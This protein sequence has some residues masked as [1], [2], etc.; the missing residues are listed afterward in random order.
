MKISNGDSLGN[1]FAHSK[2]GK[3]HVNPLPAVCDVSV[4]NVCN[5][6]CDF[7]GFARHKNLAGPRRYLDV[8]AFA[9]ALPILRR[10]RIR[11]M[12]FQGGEPL[13]HPKI[14]SLVA[15]AARAGIRIA[16]ITNGWFLPRRM[17]RLA[18]A[19]LRHLSISIDSA[20]MAE[21]ER[22]RGLKGLRHRIT[23]GIRLAHYRNIPVW[24]SVT[25]SRLVDYAALPATLASLGFD[26][27]TFSFPRRERFGSTSLVYDPE[28]PLI[29]MTVDE[30]VSALQAIERLR[31]KFPV[32][33]PAASVAEV[34]RFVR[35]EE[36][37]IPCVGGIKYFYIDWN[38]E[39]WRCEAWTE[40]MGSVFDLD[41]ISEQR[42]P[43]FGCMMACYRSASAM[44]HG[45]V[46]LTDAA[47]HVLQG[48][49]RAAMQALGRPGVAYSLRSL[50]TDRLPRMA[51]SH[52][53]RR[54]MGS[55][56]SNALQ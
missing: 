39:I 34:M 46:A 55:M 9:R 40:P 29:D 7:C 5:A 42:E 51:F 15:L 30:L 48:N 38:L 24:A 54:I 52:R 35:G 27:V 11:Y 6:A 18:E 16:L 22:N 23:K 41:S 31:N 32:T 33:N 49:V 25:V 37:R 44:M 45:A 53:T 36:Q 13:V 12:T 14:E 21:H 26:A 43:C 10:R 4:T 20:D 17:D 47:Q 28:S 3:A 2:G 50:A 1:T 19:G 56:E 8:D